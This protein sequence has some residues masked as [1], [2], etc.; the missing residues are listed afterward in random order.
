MTHPTY[1]DGRPLERACMVRLIFGERLVQFG[2]LN[3]SCFRPKQE[4]NYGSGKWGRQ[5]ADRAVRFW[6]EEGLVL[7]VTPEPKPDP[8]LAPL[9]HYMRT[10]YLAQ[11]SH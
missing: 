10:R 2:W 3:G 1:A 5:Q 6:T 8:R 11:F 9:R 4:V 7:P